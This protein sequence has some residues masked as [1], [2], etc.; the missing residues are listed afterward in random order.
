MISSL[1]I[2]TFILLFGTMYSATNKGIHVIFPA[3]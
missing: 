1:T 3:T 2:R